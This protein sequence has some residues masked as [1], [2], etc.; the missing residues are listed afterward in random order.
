MTLVQSVVV[1]NFR[2][3]AAI[4]LEFADFNSLVGANG[5]GKSNVLRA[6]NLFFTGEVE[7]GIAPDFD[8]DFHKPWRTTKRRYIEVAVCFDLG[9][10]FAVHRSIRGAL[11]ALGIAA[12]KE[13]TL[14]KTFRRA[15]VGETGLDEGMTLIS[16]AGTRLLNADESRLANRFLQLIRFRY[17]P[18]HV[19]PR[20]VVLAER[21]G[22]QEALIKTLRRK[23]RGGQ[24]G[25]FD[26]ALHA[27]SE[28]AETLVGPIN[29]TLASAPGTVEAIELAT[30]DDWADVAWSLALQMKTEGMKPMGLDL[31]GSGNQTFLMYSMLHFLDTR[32]AESFGWQ[33]AA[34]WAVEEPES[35]LHHDLKSRLATFLVDIS[36]EPRFQLFL[37]THEL[38]FAAAGDRRHD[39]S[40]SNGASQAEALDTLTLAERTLGSGVT[41]FVHPLNLTPPKPTLLAEGPSDVFYVLEAY[42]RSA[43]TNPWDVRWL[44]TLDPGSGGGKESLKKYLRANH[45]PLRARPDESPVILLLDWEVSDAE[46]ASNSALLSGHRTSRAIR[47]PETGANADLKESFVGIERFLGTDVVEAVAIDNPDA[48]ITR[49]AE[50]P[51]KYELQPKKKTEAKQRL[52]GAIRTRG[53]TA[54]LQP[55]IELL[56]WLEQHLPGAPSAHSV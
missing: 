44:E 52:E 4:E 6:L 14:T 35:F 23:R 1:Q 16:T 49:T 45:G 12:G 25:A 28:A 55:I 40:V 7:P 51:P 30:P 20:E 19:H 38:L 22:L 46:L 43:R 9:S 37:T 18:N 10:A 26:Q 48:G 17:V 56:P 24:A 15:P 39:I 32:F 29:E 53:D 54:D 34:I 31:Q 3:I 47:W 8:R 13:F 27:M 36:H 5:S 42:S 2:S 11:E 50:A 33:Q 21:A 41:S